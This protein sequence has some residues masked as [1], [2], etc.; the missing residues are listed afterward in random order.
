MAYD[1]KLQEKLLNA[2]R[3]FKGTTTEL[4]AMQAKII[5]DHEADNEA[6]KRLGPFILFLFGVIVFIL[7]SQRP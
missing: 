2:C 5:A 3:G 4:H 1:S 6:W 7:I